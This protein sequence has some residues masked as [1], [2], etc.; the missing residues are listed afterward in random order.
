MRG[1]GTLLGVPCPKI[2]LSQDRLPIEPFAHENLGEGEGTKL[3]EGK[4]KQAG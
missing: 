3:G 2:R 1:K 4:R